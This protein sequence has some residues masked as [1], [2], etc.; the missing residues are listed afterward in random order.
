MSEAKIKPFPKWRNN[1]DYF[2]CLLSFPFLGAA[3]LSLIGFAYEVS[4]SCNWT[5]ASLRVVLGVLVWNALEDHE[6]YDVRWVGTTAL[7][8]TILWGYI[9]VWPLF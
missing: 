3:A 1:L 4:L 9:K 7:A 2:L 6:D 8:F 5:L